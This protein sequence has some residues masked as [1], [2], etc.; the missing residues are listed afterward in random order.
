MDFAYNWAGVYDTW[1]S[2]RIFI[3]MCWLNCGSRSETSHESI[4]NFPVKFFLIL[5]KYVHKVI[6][7]VDL[8]TIYPFWV[9]NSTY[10]LLCLQGLYC[11]ASDE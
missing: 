1:S 8:E 3:F 5:L 4:H 10:I 7:M 11:G 2:I 9:V 6:A